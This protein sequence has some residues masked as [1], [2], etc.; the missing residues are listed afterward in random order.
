MA[1]AV[2]LVVAIGVTIATLWTGSV[3]AQMPD[4]LVQRGPWYTFVLVLAYGYAG[5][6]TIRVIAAGAAESVSATRRQLSV[7]ASFALPPAIAGLIDTFIPMLPIVAPAFF[8]SF[9]VIFV[10]LQEGQISHDALTGLNNRR[11][12]E[13]YFDEE[14]DRATA[15]NPFYYFV[16]DGDKFK[17]VND[18]CGHLE[19]DRALQAIAEAIKQAFLLVK[20]AVSARRTPIRLLYSAVGASRLSFMAPV[21]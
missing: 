17:M 19:G 21:R 15:D 7:M 11:R 9:L 10:A 20:H 16:I 12:A 5:V 2:P 13:R 6:A 1:T 18:T 8:F 3:F 14:F 4:G